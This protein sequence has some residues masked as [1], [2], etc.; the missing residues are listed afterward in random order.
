MNLLPQRLE[1]FPINH[2][3]LKDELKSLKS[4]E[5]AGLSV[6]PLV[7]IP[8]ALEEHFYHL[9]N[10]PAQLSKLFASINLKRPDEDELEDMAVQAQN[11]IKKHFFLDEVIDMI[12]STLKPMPERLVLRHPDE[13]GLEVFNGRPALMAIKDLW[14]KD[15]A[16]DALLERI[17]KTSSIAIT[18][19]PIIIQGAGSN[20]SEMLSKKASEVLGKLTQ[21][22]ANLQGIT[23]VVLAP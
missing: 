19:R 4:L 14:T 21:V 1:S 17:E 23:R 20:S 22:E 3:D 10:L 18:E 11:L 12:Y 13:K 16:F 5:E 7:V 8:A 15:W 9:N 2:P 6:A